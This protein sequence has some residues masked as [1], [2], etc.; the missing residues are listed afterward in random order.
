M[1]KNYSEYIQCHASN[2]KITKNFNNILIEYGTWYLANFSGILPVTSQIVNFAVR[3]TLA[4]RLTI[5]S[6]FST[7]RIAQS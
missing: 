1:Q 4:D 5:N 3:F 2:V 7:Y 6:K